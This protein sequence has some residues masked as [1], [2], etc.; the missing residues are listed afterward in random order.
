MDSATELLY[1]YVAWQWPVKGI[2]TLAF[3][4][5]AFKLAASILRHIALFAIGCK[6][7]LRNDPGALY[8][9]P[10]LKTLGWWPRSGR[11]RSLLEGIHRWLYPLSYSGSGNIPMHSYRKLRKRPG[12]DGAD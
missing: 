9:P 2:V 4:A 3:Y 6:R 5:V 8:P 7:L 12:S 1:D 10:S 11:L